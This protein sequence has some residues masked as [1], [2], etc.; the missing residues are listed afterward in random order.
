V[1]S[2]EP[3]TLALRLENYPA[4]AVYV[5]GRQVQSTAR[6][7]VQQILV[8]IERGSSLVE[9]RFRRTRDR[10]WGGA[11]SMLTAT[12]LCGL[13]WGYRRRRIIGT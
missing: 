3:V 13:A 5:N 9:V 12:A 6:P 2:T 4:W 10:A 8:P 11:I 1:D 7:P